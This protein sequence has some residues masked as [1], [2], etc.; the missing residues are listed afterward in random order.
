MV[1]PATPSVHTLLMPPTSGATRL[2]E[3]KLR[4]PV[5]G[6]DA[7]D[8]PRLTSR[9]EGEPG[10]QVTLLS[11]PAGYGK[12]TLVAG[13]L[14]GRGAA[15]SAW[16]TLDPEDNDPVRLWTYLIAAL[17]AATDGGTENPLAG[18]PDPQRVDPQYVAEV[19]ARVGA[20]PVPVVLVLDNAHCL[21][22]GPAADSLAVLLRHPLRQL[23][24]VLCARGAPALPV[25]RLRVTGELVQLS[26]ADLAFTPAEIGQLARGT[27]RPLTEE[28]ARTLHDRTGGWAAGLRLLLDP[29]ERP[30]EAVAAYFRTEVLADQ[31]PDTQDF[32]LQTS[33][34]DELTGD[35]ADRLTGRRD[36]AALLQQ[37][38]EEDVLRTGTDGYRH[39]PLF[40][41]FLRAEAAVR[42]PAELA[43]LHL[44]AAY[45]YAAQHRP[46]TGVPHALA[47]RQ[48]PYA[49]GLLVRYGIPGL[50]PGAVPV[51]DD[52]DTPGRTEAQRLHELVERLPR[53]QATREPEIAVLY[54][55]VTVV[56]GDLAAADRYRS[57][58]GAEREPLDDARRYP[59]QALLHLIDLLAARRRADQPAALTAAGA[60]LAQLDT[61]PPGTVPAAAAYRTVALAG[62]G[63]AQL[64]CGLLDE[65]D[66]TLRRAGTAAEATG[67]STM[68]S[69]GHRALLLALQGRLDAATELARTAVSN[70]CGPIAL[71]LVHWL[72]GDTEEA[73]R[74]LASTRP[75]EAS[76]GL[77]HALVQA[78]VFRSNGEP[79]A[80]RAQLTGDR[81][82]PPFLQDWRTVARAELEVAAR[83]PDAALAALAGLL[84]RPRLELAGAWAHT[85]AARAQLTRGAPAQ[86]RALLAPLLKAEPEVAVGARIDAWLLEALAAD[87]MGYEGTVRIAL[88]EALAAAAPEG[89]RRPFIDAGTPLSTLLDRH[90]DLG[91]PYGNAWAR[92]APPP[93]DTTAEPL[94]EREAIVLRYL[95]SLLTS[96]DIAR[97]LS[98]SPNTVKTQLKSLYRKLSVGN[99]RD[100]VHRARQLKLL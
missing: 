47:A 5:P 7:L 22:P 3:A 18:L 58:A 32:L 44:R 33:V 76:A 69:Q 78:Q 14:A 68:D 42:L 25:P 35:L 34:V 92:P 71:G 80:A 88:S 63:A 28:Q 9:L 24:L 64:W 98:V 73:E 48:W 82:A 6:R 38:H 89:Y 74:Q 21:R 97:E 17:R 55:L 91:E 15:P 46:L 13:W 2:V 1:E 79:A 4:A 70:G 11:A 8:R 30:D 27:D 72:R 62:A 90:H 99:R 50:L 12:T 49:A 86:A 45:W 39:Y 81:P 84:R 41:E 75:A 40:G 19:A 56:R 10:R 100:A 57:L 61:A 67:L 23:P 29:T 51:A 83:R 16:V 95:P 53:G 93:R 60:L 85:A 20:L 43:A 77:A 52:T 65:A 94:T 87:Q 54:A 66:E 59:R 36:G 37:L 96:I 26:A 31:P